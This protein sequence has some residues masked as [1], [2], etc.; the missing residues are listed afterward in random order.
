MTNTK[1]FK[2]TPVFAVIVLV[3]IAMISG[4]LL[5]ILS[6]VL[7]VS[8]EEKTQRALAKVGLESVPTLGI[9]PERWNP[10]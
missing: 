2:S 10:A 6:D 8:P 7:Y 5:S 3:C 9:S 4:I 1:S